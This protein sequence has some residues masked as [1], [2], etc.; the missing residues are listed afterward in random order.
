MDGLILLGRGKNKETKKKDCN[1][2]RASH[3]VKIGNKQERIKDGE[4]RRWQCGGGTA[5]LEA[6]S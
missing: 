2:K 3:M 6:T 4:A 1:L 5:R